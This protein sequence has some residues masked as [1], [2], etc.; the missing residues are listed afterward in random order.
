MLTPEEQAAMTFVTIDKQLA[1]CA[2]NE[3][4]LTFNPTHIAP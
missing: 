3:G 4:F 2:A 1:G